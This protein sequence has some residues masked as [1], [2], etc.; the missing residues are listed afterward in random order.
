MQWLCVLFC[1]YLL[2]QMT[3]H[4]PLHLHPSLQ[5]RYAIIESD[6]IK[7]R[8]AERAFIAGEPLPGSM[9]KVTFQAPPYR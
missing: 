9:G 6:I 7:P 4:T 8:N 5:D 2:N 3:Q 1:F